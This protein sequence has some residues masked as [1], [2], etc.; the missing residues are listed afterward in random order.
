M[1]FNFCAQQVL[2][3][4]LTFPNF[5]KNLFDSFQFF[6]IRFH[7]EGEGKYRVLIM[8]ITALVKTALKSYYS[9]LSL[10]A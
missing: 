8:E 3:L 7:M 6:Q 9:M 5:K 2:E 4:P 10:L 1:K